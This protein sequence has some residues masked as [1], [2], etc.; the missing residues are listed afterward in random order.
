MI[1]LHS[2]EFLEIDI[3]DLLIPS[4]RVA[5]VQIGN[6][7]EHTLLVLTKSGYTAIPVLDPH[8]KLHGLISTPMIMESILGLQRIEFDQL[9]E[10]RVE[11]FMNHDIPRLN[12]NTSLR[13]AT[14]LLVDHP[15][16]CVEDDEGYFEGILTRRSLLVQLQKALH[17]K[18][19][20]D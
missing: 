18:K 2:E 9:E 10:K 20:K 1:S 19:K 13:N 5:H 4:E 11:E 3:K 12:I 8:Y 14:G 17:S 6:N 15:F 16:I 7:L